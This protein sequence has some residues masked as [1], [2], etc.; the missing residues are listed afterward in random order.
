M[1]PFNDFQNYEE[2]LRSMRYQDIV[3]LCRVNQRFRQI[4]NSARGKQIIQEV[5]DNSIDNLLD[6]LR[7]EIL[8]TLKGEYTR[9]INNTPSKL[10]SSSKIRQLINEYYQI[11][12]DLAIKILA[13]K[14]YPRA[15]Y[16]DLY[17]YFK[18]SEYNRGW[19][20]FHNM[21]VDTSPSSYRKETRYTPDIN[22][23]VTTLHQYGYEAP[24]PLIIQL[25]IDRDPN[26]DMSNDE[27]TD[28]VDSTFLRNRPELIEIFKSINLNL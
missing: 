17:Q 8:V 1:N 26:F 20:M 24:G 6:N 23:F 3:Q 4:C 25:L 7:E 19:D 18:T 27:Y 9:S 28:E 15:F 10:G 2:L 12:T 21:Y 11:E 22:N 16:R 5:L 13:D 14:N